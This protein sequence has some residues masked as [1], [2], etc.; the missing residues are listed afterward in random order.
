MG[1]FKIDPQSWVTEK[2]FDLV[3]KLDGER[4]WYR[5][6]GL[7]SVTIK[8]ITRA[9]KY[10][11]VSKIVRRVAASDAIDYLLKTAPKKI[12][13]DAPPSVDLKPVAKPHVSLWQQLKD[14]LVDAPAAKY[15][16]PCDPADADSDIVFLEVVRR[17]NGGVFVNKLL[18]APGDWHRAW[19][20][21]AQQL[22]WAK[23]ITEDPTKH[24]TTYCVKF[25]RC[26]ACDSPLSNA[27]S[28]AEAM[29]PVCRKKFKW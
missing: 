3:R 16:L 26:A 17:K 27:Q 28:I 6:P 13:D 1:V 10:Q 22:D 23:R 20:T 25:T 18:G 19:L 21:P 11:E 7:V 29:G 9:Q 24:A 2:Q 14:T 8:R 5:A 15:A 4:D 12:S